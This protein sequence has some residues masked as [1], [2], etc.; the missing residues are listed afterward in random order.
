MSQRET[1]CISSRK[2][3]KQA[4]SARLVE[5]ILQAATQV[6]L[7]EGMPRFTTARVAE[8]AGVS[9]GSLYQYFPNKAA[10]LFALQSDEW[11]QNGTLL[12]SILL[13]ETL[14][15]EQRLRQ[16]VLTFVQSEYDEVALRSALEHAAPYYHDA[17]EVHQARDR[18]QEAIELMMSQVLAGVAGEE[19]L[20][21][22]TLIWT[23]LT[24]VGKRLS[25]T[26]RSQ[27]ELSDYA[28][29]LADMC[30]AYRLSATD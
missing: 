29:R 11:Q 27:Q 28:A 22:A 5:A 9:I 19:R 15:P 2:S 23:T 20:Q 1:P 24:S 13:D 4:R 30:C 14:Q 21:V 12:R 3:P 26:A 18:E 25:Q 6:L 16:L 10:L 8:R 7:Q 17:P